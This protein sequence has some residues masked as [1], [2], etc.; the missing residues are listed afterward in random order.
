[1]ERLS[2]GG[3]NEP[4]CLDYSDSLFQPRDLCAA[5]PGFSTLQLYEAKVENVGILPAYAEHDGVHNA[6]T[7]SA[8]L[9]FKERHT[10]AIL[11]T[12]GP[13]SLFAGS[14]RSASLC[15]GVHS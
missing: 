10:P 15:E 7:R 1:M 4:I 14:L 9:A 5:Y 12:V 3:R 13:Q 2:I 8:C 6:G 11:G